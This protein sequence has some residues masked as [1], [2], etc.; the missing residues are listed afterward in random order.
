MVKSEREGR[1]TETETTMK[2]NIAGVDRV[3]SKSRTRKTILEASAVQIKS[4]ET[5]DLLMPINKPGTET[6]N[7]FTH[8]QFMKSCTPGGN[9]P[10]DSNLKPEVIAQRDETIRV[11]AGTFETHYAKI[12]MTTS[13]PNEP[14]REM[15][16]ETWTSIAQPG[17]LVKL[18]M[19]SESIEE[20]V[21]IKNNTTTELIQFRN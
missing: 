2:M 6:I 19:T 17:L 15:F 7:T 8:D 16:S 1:F 21:T 10:P 20:G 3:A 12:K 13:K 9:L 18:T 4:A 11:R 14:V 5:T